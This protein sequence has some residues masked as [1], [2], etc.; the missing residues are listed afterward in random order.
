MKKKYCLDCKTELGDYRSIR[1]P[2]CN[3]KFR[4][5]NKKRFFC[6]DCGKELSRP[7]AKR[8]INCYIIWLKENYKNF[9]FPSN[10]GINNGFFSKHHTDEVK[11]ILSELN[12]GENHPNWQGGISF[13]PYSPLWTEELKIKIRQRDNCECQNCNMT[14]EEHFI[15][16]GCDLNVHHIDYDK[17]NC[18]E[19]NLITTC[20]WCNCRA[21]SNRNYWQD[22]YNNKIEL[23]KIKGN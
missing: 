9:N 20:L 17:K 22:F 16:A 21:N 5:G 4:H 1:C 19:E 11:K 2:N 12:K 18:N 6:E 3:F 15:V 8:C 7:D 13:E 10:K 14:Q 23:I